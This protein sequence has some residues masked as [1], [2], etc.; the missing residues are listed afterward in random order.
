MVFF[1]V[2]IILMLTYE[3]Q[4]PYQNCR[5]APWHVSTI[6]LFHLFLVGL[7]SCDK[8]VFHS[9]GGVGGTTDGIH[10]L[11]EGFVDG[12]T[13]PGFIEAAFDDTFSALDYQTDAKL[14]EA[15]NQ[16]IKETK[17]T[18]FIVAQRI[19]TIMHSDRIIVLDQGRIAGQGTHEELL[20]T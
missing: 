15:L 6:S 19:S 1:I 14:R 17:A 2:N 8:A 3:S 16:M 18:V 5:D 7:Q 10:F 9:S 12:E 20:K 13:V 4:I 11:V